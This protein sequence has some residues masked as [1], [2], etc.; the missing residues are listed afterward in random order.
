MFF[1]CCDDV[2]LVKGK[3]EDADLLYQ[4]AVAIEEK[5]YGPD[6]PE[7]ASTLNARSSLLEQI[8]IKLLVKQRCFLMIM[9]LMRLWRRHK[10]RMATVKPFHVLLP[11]SKSVRLHNSI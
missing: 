11:R 4:R 10:T 3:Y 8:K 5:V 1:V 6:H 7:V 2:P 9:R